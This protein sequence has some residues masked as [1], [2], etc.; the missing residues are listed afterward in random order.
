[1]A[2]IAEMA[3]NIGADTS[4]FER[5]TRRMERG[6]SSVGTEMRQM[7]ASLGTSARDMQDRWRDMSEEMRDAY[8]RSN[9]A[10][11][12]FR[13]QQQEVEHGFFR[14]SQGMSDYQGSTQEFMQELTD[15]GNRNRQV[16]DQMMANNDMAR[17]GFIRGVATMLARSTQSSKI[18]ANFDRMNNPLYR[19]NNG[20]LAISGGMERIANRG[21]PAALALRM[22]G[23]TANMKQLADM[24]R[25]ITAGLMRFQ[26]VA[27]AAV[28]VN[29]LM[30]SALH[31]AA[32]DSVPGYEDAMK[33]M[34]GAI[35]KAFQ[36]M[37]EVFAA[38]M[39][40]IAEFITMIANLAIKF[41][42]A[43]PVLA[44]V[45][46]GFLMLIP[47]LTLLLAP[48]AIGIG[49]FAGMQAAFASVWVLIAPIVTGLA[50]MMGTVLLVAGAIALLVA[51][52]VLLWN[53]SEAFRN[54]VIAGWEA[55]KA[56]AIAIWNFLY[57][58]AIK[59]TIDAIV[60]FVQAKLA[61]L[62]AFWDEN[63][64][65]ITEAAKNVWN[66]LY[67][68]IIRP[69][70][71]A[72]VAIMKVLWPIVKAVVI[73]VWNAIKQVIS[74]AVDVI[75]GIIKFF[76]ALFTGNWKALWEA[77]KQIFSGA[78]NVLLGWLQL[79]FFGGIGK[80][81]TALGAS[82]RTGFTAAWNF[83]KS[84]FSSGISSVTG[85]V[86]SGFNAVVNFITGLGKTFFNAGK[87]L[88]EMMAN[89][90]KSA[91]SAVLNA[92][93]SLAQKA[94]N[95]LPFSPAKEGPLSDLDHLDF[96]GPITD[97]IN[98]AIPMVKGLMGDLLSLPD[99]NLK[100]SEGTYGSSQPSQI[101][102]TLNYNGTGGREDAVEMLDVIE[103]GLNDRLGLKL[104]L[105]GVR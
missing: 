27:M 79:Q 52:I 62:K 29:A 85:V 3:V 19:V 49:L 26:M 69:V 41:N 44:K 40:K 8:R 48:L 15:L 50:S 5:G 87:G 78:I 20:L 43:H 94:R 66:F 67:N 88:I 65:M 2:T 99:M 10:L 91:A 73:S 18:A 54:A 53:K 9:E 47:I 105:N 25:L 75:L 23:P 39:M 72:I 6:I 83:V 17:M 84:I 98:K 63:G 37:V 21:Q 55:I 45:I 70:M 36:P 71:T 30:F 101:S 12:P 60:M 104:R 16:N 34:G 57:N 97:S 96:G 7:A 28:V 14:L 46:Q 56:A 32:K 31:Q 59:P 42:E 81:I 89:G 22:L 93:K 51:G 35:R 4:E 80:G 61:Q 103:R 1:M 74:G 24:T 77:T 90:I 102:L 64:Q 100:T 13:Q 86:R 76:S 38:V 82:M 68:G 92:V 95:F 33:K 11:R 58:N